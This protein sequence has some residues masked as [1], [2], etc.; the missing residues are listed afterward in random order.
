MTAMQPSGNRIMLTVLLAS[1]HSVSLPGILLERQ[2]GAKI[3]LQP[4]AA[5]N[6]PV[7]NIKKGLS[8]IS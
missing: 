8:F 6:K 7:M 2:D 1:S 3:G 4:A 5:K